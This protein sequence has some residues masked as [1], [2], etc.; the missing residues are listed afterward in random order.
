METLCSSK[1]SAT[2]HHSTQH[3]IQEVVHPYWRM[4]SWTR[5][6]VWLSVDAQHIKTKVF[7]FYS[8]WSF[9]TVPTACSHTMLST[10]ADKSVSR[11]AK[12][13]LKTHIITA[14]TNVF[15]YTTQ[16]SLVDMSRRFRKTGC[17]YADVFRTSEYTRIFQIT[18]FRISEDIYFRMYFLQKTKPNTLNFT[19]AYHDKG[20]TVR[21]KNM[22]ILFPKF[23]GKTPFHVWS[24]FLH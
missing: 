6:F 12:L 20:I 3:H 10:W 19:C 9:T 23:E 18:E 16:C 21:I 22:P 4:R 8:I 15:W 11:R 5:N 17:L 1:T 14:K 7:A 2:V 24:L 13:F